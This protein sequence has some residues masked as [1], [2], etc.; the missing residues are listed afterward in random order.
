M[1]LSIRHRRILCATLIVGLPPLVLAGAWRLAGAAALEDDLI[2]Y[3]P[4]RAFIGQAV[5]GGEWPLWNPHTALGTSLAADPQGGLWYPPTLLFVA[6]PALWAYPMTIC[7][8]FSLAG[9]GMYRFLRACGRVWPA[10]LLGAVAFEF[11]GFLVGHRAH[12]TILQATAWLPWILFAWHRFAG[13]G[14]RRHFAIAAVCLGLQTLVQHTQITILGAAITTAYVAFV[15]TPQRRSLLWQYPLGSALGAMIAGVQLLPTLAAFAD[16][17]RGS[18]AYYLFVENSYAPTSFFLWLFPFLF[19]A[20]TPNFYDRPWW[21]WS[22]YCEQA[23]YA[24]IAVLLLAVAA[25]ALWRRDRQVRFWCVLA[26]VCLVLAL[27]KFTPLAGLLFHVPVLQ[28]FRAPARWIVGFDVAMVALAAA[29]VDAFL[30]GGPDA[31]LLRRRLRTVVTR[32]LPAMA[33]VSLLCMVVARVGAPRLFNDRI[34]AD[35]AAAI[36]PANPAIW[37]PLAL[38]LIT[39]AVLWNVCSQPGPALSPAGAGGGWDRRFGAVFAV[40]LVDLAS[41]AAFVDV[42]VREYPNARALL[43]SS[44][45]QAIGGRSEGDGGRLWVPRTAADYTRPVEVLSPQM[46]LLHGIDTFHGYGPMWPAA[47]RLLL[48]FMP[49][50][51]SQDALDLLWNPKLLQTL[52]V[53][54]L[55]ARSEQERELMSLACAGPLP[56]PVLTTCDGNREMRLRGTV[57]RWPVAPDRP[58]VYAAEFRVAP[59]ADNKDRWYFSLV[60]ASDQDVG[61]TFWYEPADHAGGPRTMRAV[62]LCLRPAPGASLR[63]YG[64]PRCD[65]AI[66]GVRFGRVADWPPRRPTQTPYRQVADLAGGVTLYELPDARPRFAW[67]DRVT[68]VNAVAE[69]VERLRFDPDGVGLPTGAVVESPFALRFDEPGETGPRR[70]AAAIRVTSER[71]NCI[72]LRVSA[73]RPG[74]LVFND[75]FDAGWMATIDGTPSS[76]LRTNAAVQSVSVPSGEHT[77]V[78]RYWPTGLTPGIIVSVAGCIALV[79]MLAMPNRRPRRA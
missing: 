73:A 2:Y 6:L 35:I 42:D 34:A 40:V 71:L 11:C 45:A 47:N 20:R 1:I 28:S 50:G 66:S 60:D 29:G 14:R 3:L 10:A 59:G 63:A 69:A 7:L 13:T 52:G 5:R 74:L 16:G 24:S 75:S 53:R 62:F 25:I 54:W 67:T 57:A 30:R 37:M 27:G 19:G 9:T 61:A 72:T 64:E 38:M 43:D 46:N 55:A 31:A 68:T 22:H 49:W 44:L 12:L 48:R 4:V 15:L 36:T 70:E 65:V 78:W 23:T 76:I 51:S 56:S 39:A 17:T 33:A 18:P 58:G 21:G 32:V 8:H 41:V 79:G 26:V 77:V